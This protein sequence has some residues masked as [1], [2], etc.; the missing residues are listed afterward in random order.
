MLSDKEKALRFPG[1]SLVELMVATAILTIILGII[2]T[3]TSQTANA[4]KSSQSRIESFQAARAAFESM[5]RRISQA[6]LN[7]YY[8]YDNPS[9][10]RRYLRRSDLHFIAGKSLCPQQITH[11]IFFQA[12]LGYTDA[13]KYVGL[14]NTLNACGYYV[15]YNADTSRPAFIETLPNPPPPR[16]R[17]RLMQFV[18]PAQELGVYEHQG[19][20]DPSEQREWFT[21]PLL[22]SAPPTRPLADNVI[23][24]VILPK[25]SAGD[26]AAVGAPLTTDYEYDTRKSAP[27]GTAQLPGENQLPPLVEV[28]LVAIDE[29]SAL[30]LGTSVAAPELLGNSSTLFQTCD[31]LEE[32]IGKL[33]EILAAAPGNSAD[34]RTRLTYRLFR[35]EVPL[36]GA[37]WSSD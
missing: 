25:R 26:E 31:Q 34:N 5:T 8:D 24:L 19:S 28:L 11:A 37:K 29:P 15:E 33:Q 35:T 2:F 14:D 16:R 17:F 12:P 20:A 3:L 6:T 10:P 18:E 21:G 13:A 1:F 32:D 36:K 4:W 27:A 7:N 22:Q 30:K 23:A 9:T